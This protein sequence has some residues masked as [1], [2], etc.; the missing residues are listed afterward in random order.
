MSDTPEQDVTT[1][2][3]SLLQSLEYHEKSPPAVEIPGG[4]F[5][6]LHY[7][8]AAISRLTTISGGIAWILAWVVFVLGLFNVITR[9]AG[10]FIQRDI[11]IGEIFDLQWMLF[12]ALFLL[13]FN[14]GVREAV[15]PRIDFWWT[16]FSDKT[17]ALIDLIIHAT[18]LLPFL[19]LGVRLLWPYAMSALGRKFDGKWSTWKVWEIWEQ[20]TDAAGLPRGPIKFLMLFGFILFALQVVAEIIKTIMVLAGRSD[21]A[22]IAKPKAPVRIE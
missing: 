15:N 22:T 7:I 1:I 2:A 14:Y 9:Y 6:T 8:R 18:L 3:E 4:V 12:G 16:N 19:W 5:G 20:S 17:K 10:R 21:L 11:I 13:A